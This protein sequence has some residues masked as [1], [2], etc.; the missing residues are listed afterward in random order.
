VEYAEG[1][2]SW[3]YHGEKIKCFSQKKFERLIKLKY[4]W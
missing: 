4:L 2:K 3:Y 1:Y